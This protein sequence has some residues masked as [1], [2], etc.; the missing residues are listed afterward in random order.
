MRNILCSRDEQGKKCWNKPVILMPFAFIAG[1]VI[2]GTV[3]ML[4]WNAI[5]PEIIG[6]H[7]ISFW[8][9]LGLLVISKILFTGIHGRHH[10]FGFHDH[11]KELREKWI[12]MSSE[13]REKMR[14]ELRNRFHPR[15]EQD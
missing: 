8:Q 10:H 9:A 7:A 3:L 2:F 5:L 13:E 1:T 12:S 15:A 14:S 6:V 11:S 4:L